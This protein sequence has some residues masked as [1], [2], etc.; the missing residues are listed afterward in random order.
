MIVGWRGSGWSFCVHEHVRPIFGGS[1]N[2]VD[3]SVDEVPHAIQATL[4]STKQ[5][6]AKPFPKG[7]APPFSVTKQFGV[8]CNAARLSDSQ[9]SWSTSLITN[10]GP[11]GSQ[12]HHA[13]SKNVS[14]IAHYD[15]D[16]LV[17]TQ[18]L[19]WAP[20]ELGKERVIAMGSS[21]LSVTSHYTSTR[22]A[23]FF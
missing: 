16:F 11:R 19:N 12:K 21:L 10:H 17:A 15:S 14:Y 22:P 6:K 2:T 8:Y 3:H 23:P 7:T 13:N 5:L 18:T 20:I 9:W 4:T 1:S